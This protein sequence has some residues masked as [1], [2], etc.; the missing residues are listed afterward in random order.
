VR[1]HGEKDSPL[2]VGLTTKHEFDL[3]GIADAPNGWTRSY[4]SLAKDYGFYYHTTN[5]SI[6]DK[7]HG[8]TRTIA[9]QFGATAAP[10]RKYLDDAHHDVTLTPEERYRI[11]LWLDANSVFYGT[12][13]NPRTQ[14]QGKDVMPS[15]E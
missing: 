7:L 6:N 10:L 15:L 4:Q 1:C 13:E 8:G 14:A 11:D 3:R 12:Y 2:A 9:G 5:G